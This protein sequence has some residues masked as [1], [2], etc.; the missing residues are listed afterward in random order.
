VGAVLCLNPYGLC[1]PIALVMA[2]IAAL[3]LSKTRRPI[4]FWSGAGYICKYFYPV[5]KKMERVKIN[6]PAAPPLFETVIPVRIGDVNY[7]GHMG[8]DAFLTLMHEAR[9]QWLRS[10]GFDELNAG[11]VSLILSDAQIA[12]RAEAFYGD[13]LKVRLFADAVTERSFDLLYHV[14]VERD[15]R[16]VDVVHAVVMMVCFDYSSRR[17]ARMTAELKALLGG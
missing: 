14:S 11:G 8:N 10:H 5:K 1:R 13:P 3:F 7:G 2:A 17:V 6:F 9:M 16:V 15:G 12:Y 4:P